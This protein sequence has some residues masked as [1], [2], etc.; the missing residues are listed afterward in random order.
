MIESAPT[1]PPAEVTAMTAGASVLSICVA[2]GSMIAW[3]L[4]AWADGAAPQN[5]AHLDA[6]LCFGCAAS[7]LLLLADITGICPRGFH[8]LALVTTSLTAALA[9]ANFFT[10]EPSGLAR[11]VRRRSWRVKP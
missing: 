3:S 4:G 6:I 9:V 10:K 8:R 5:V 2:I 11:H 7:L 1:Q